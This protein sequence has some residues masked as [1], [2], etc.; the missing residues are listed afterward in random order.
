MKNTKKLVTALA[1][2]FALLGLAGCNMLGGENGGEGVPPDPKEAAYVEVIP[3]I[4]EETGN[5][6]EGLVSVM[7]DGKWGFIDETGAEVIPFIYDAA[8]DFSEGLAAVKLDGRAGY[9]DKTGAEVIPFI[10]EGASDFSEGLA[11][12][13]YP[14]IP[15]LDPHIVFINKTGEVIT[16]RYYSAEP[17]TE[18]LAVVQHG[19]MNYVYI[20]TSGTEVISIEGTNRG[21]PFSNGLA[22]IYHFEDKYFIDK[23]GA[24]VIDLESIDGVSTFIGSTESFSD[25]LA[26][27]DTHNI[28]EKGNRNRGYID[29]TGTLV[30]TT[31][32]F[33]QGFSE[34]LAVVGFLRGMGYIDLTG[35]VVIEGK[36]DWAHDFSDGFAAVE[37]DGKMGFINKEGEEVVPFVYDI[38]VLSLGEFEDELSWVDEDGFAMY[39][40]KV[41]EGMAAVQL[42]GK[43]GFI[44]LLK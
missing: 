13:S 20:D 15:S 32:G 11:A 31:E 43:W 8:F 40:K 44:K 3:F 22:L 9:I 16:P 27:V 19:M 42:D 18:G 28:P 17:F 12:V 38:P 6:S 14:D 25:G 2:T 4:Y 34:G 10:Y 23:T 26:L 33:A 41:S 1:L 21:K 37:L 29:T 7:L 35:E 36:Y 24:V 30:F 39:Y 5:F